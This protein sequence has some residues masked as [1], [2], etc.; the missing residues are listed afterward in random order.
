MGFE[1]F[2]DVFELLS[3]LCYFWHI[4]IGFKM[5]AQLVYCLGKEK[6]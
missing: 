5:A 2:L 3:E 4:P 6:E 1:D